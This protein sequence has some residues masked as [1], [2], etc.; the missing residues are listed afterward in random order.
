MARDLL[1]AASDDLT[2][3]AESAEGDLRERIEGQAET[4]SKLASA[5]RGPDHGRLARH[6]NALAEIADRSD[7]DV[8]EKVES[9]RDKVSEYREGVAG[10]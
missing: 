1:E 8:R 10:V 6:M 3:A 9:A 4:L 2:A 5:D 7:G